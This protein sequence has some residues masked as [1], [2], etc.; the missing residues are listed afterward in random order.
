MMTNLTT[1]IQNILSAVF[2]LGAGHRPSVSDLMIAFPIPLP[3][4]T[5]NGRL[6]GP[7]DRWVPSPLSENTVALRGKP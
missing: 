4:S 2:S 5:K 7:T 6:T 3:R 1:L